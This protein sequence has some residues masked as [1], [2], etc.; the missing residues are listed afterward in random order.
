VTDYVT[1]HEGETLEDAYRRSD[2]DEFGY[3]VPEELIE[4]REA[5][6]R[7]LDDANGAI[8]RY[9]KDNNVPE[10]ELDDELT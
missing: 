10:V 5:A 6:E 4:R 9:I 3:L 7:A 1:H 2:G 8:R